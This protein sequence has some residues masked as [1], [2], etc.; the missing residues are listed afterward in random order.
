MVEV[1]VLSPSTLTD[2]V[3]SLDKAVINNFSAQPVVE[4]QL[5]QAGLVFF[6]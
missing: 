3:N 6:G 1:A 2:V 4:S 5:G